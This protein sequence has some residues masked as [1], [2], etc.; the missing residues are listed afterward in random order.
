MLNL[1]SGCISVKDE[2]SF[3]QR[4]CL[5]AKESKQGVTILLYISIKDDRKEKC[6]FSVGTQGYIEGQMDI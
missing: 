2:M 5:I 1:E 3:L 6:W 4:L